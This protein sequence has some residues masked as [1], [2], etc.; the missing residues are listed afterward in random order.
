MLREIIILRPV[1]WL[2]NV[3]YYLY[4]LILSLIF[5]L[6]LPFYLVAF[7]L[8]RKGNL[9]DALRIHNVRYGVFLTKIL[10][11]LVRIDRSGRDNVPA[12]GT[13]LAVFNHRSAADIVFSSALPR[14]NVGVIVRSWPFR[15]PI[16]GWYMRLA[17]YIDI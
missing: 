8:L 15:L 4:M 3:V 14:P 9:A 10:R 11:P 5:E 16:T 17:R 7:L 1:F 13:V 12:N 6:H 2:A